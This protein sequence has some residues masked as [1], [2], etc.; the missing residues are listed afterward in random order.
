LF[1]ERA[2]RK[3]LREMLLLEKNFH[4]KTTYHVFGFLLAESRQ[5]ISEE[6]HCLAFYSFDHETD[7]NDQL[8]RCRKIDYRIKGCCPFRYQITSEFTDIN[9]AFH[10][11]EW[12]AGA[13]KS[14]KTKAPLMK[15]GIV[16]IP[17]YFDDSKMVQSGLDY[18]EWE[19]Q[20]MKTI[21]NNDFV[22]FCLHDCYGHFWLSNYER[23]LEK[24]L[25]LAELKTMN[26]VST[27]V[28]L[29]HSI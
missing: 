26:Q 2:S 25:K 28:V 16:R 12:I 11:F 13:T 21:R 5:A 10:N 6:G 7:R 27:Q 18:L 14:F 20:A 24:I 29:S 15:N 17:V 22:S 3:N 9:L 4:V 23:F 8:P 1:S 19:R